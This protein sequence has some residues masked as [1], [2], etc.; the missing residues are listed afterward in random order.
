MTARVLRLDLEYDGAGFS[1]WAAQP[2]L[3]T[4]EGVLRDA[5]ETLV[6]H[7]VRLTV[8]GRTDAGVHA[9]G[10]V[11]SVS[12]ATGLGAERIRR[13]LAGILPHDVAARAVSDAP[14]GFD[15]RADA[16]S[17]R[18]EYRLLVGPDSP[19][20][21]GR[22]HEVRRPLDTAAM[23]DAAGL[24]VGRHDFSAFTP[25]RTEHV[26]FHRTVSECRLDTRSDELVFVIEADAF[27][28]SMVR[29]V[30]GTLVEVGAGRRST[31]DVARLL[32]GAPRDAAGPT[33]P[34]H[35]LTLVAVRYGVPP[36]TSLG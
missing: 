20:R 7:P 2:G 6:R 32:D 26:F 4:V 15:A 24:L 34:A 11:A 8:A 13:G 22:V 28:R 36:G 16:L 12:V 1:G 5:L 17:R 27:L 10:Q 21:R 18:Y 30:A 35:G 31:E 19:L 25:T 9:S 3:R 23:R 29:T 33:L 14:A